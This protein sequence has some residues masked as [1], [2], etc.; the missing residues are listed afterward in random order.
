MLEL[1]SAL[2]ANGDTSPVKSV[3]GKQIGGSILE[4]QRILLIGGSA[5]LTGLNVLWLCK[6]F[7]GIWKAFARSHRNHCCEDSKS[8]QLNATDTGSR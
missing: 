6:I 3:S 4:T 7:T 2:R 5:G 1:A 8:S